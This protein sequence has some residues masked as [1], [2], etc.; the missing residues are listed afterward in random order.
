MM[1]LE[2]HINTAF[3]RSQHLVAFIELLVTQEL[4]GTL[5]L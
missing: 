4:T 2:L 3:K 1:S 5:E